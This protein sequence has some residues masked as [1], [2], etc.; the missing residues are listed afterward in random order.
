MVESCLD[1]LMSLYLGYCK[2]VPAKERPE[3]LL[4]LSLEFVIPVL[5]RF[6]HELY[7]SYCSGEETPRAAIARS[8]M[9]SDL[10]WLHGSKEVGHR[11]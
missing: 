7:T 5:F 6:R 2:P 10:M 4:F 8:K 9:A 11:I 3:H 1:G